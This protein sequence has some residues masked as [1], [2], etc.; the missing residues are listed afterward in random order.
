MR[1]MKLRDGRR[2]GGLLEWRD[3]CLDVNIGVTRRQSISL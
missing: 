1:V 3:G 2:Q